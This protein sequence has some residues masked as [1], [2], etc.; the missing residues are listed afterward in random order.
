MIILPASNLIEA[1]VTSTHFP[2]MV[3]E[4]IVQ[5][6][7]KALASRR[8]ASAEAGRAAGLPGT[9]ELWRESHP[10]IAIPIPIATKKRGAIMR[11]D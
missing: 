11:V 5:L 1:P 2:A 4:T 6:P 7:S 3:S 10:T 8:R 9:G